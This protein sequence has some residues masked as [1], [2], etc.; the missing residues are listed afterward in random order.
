MSSV[1][2]DGRLIDKND[3]RVSVF[4]HGFLFGD[5][6]WEGM[7][8]FDGSVF[9][10]GDHLASL[11]RSARAI[12]LEIPLGP[13]ELVNAIATTLKAND[14]RDGYVRVIVSRGAGTLG[15]DPRKC[16][17]MVIVIAEEIGQYPRELTDH[18]IET[19]AVESPRP[20]PPVTLL[21][22]AGF[23]TAKAAALRAGCFEALLFDPDSIL[24][25]ASEAAVF[26]VSS[27][28]VDT[29]SIDFG[30]LEP[31]MRSAVLELVGEAGRP[32]S[33][34]PVD[35][36]AISAADEV[37]LASAAGG[38]MAV[39]KLDGQPIGDGRVG[40]VT[41]QIQGLLAEAVRERR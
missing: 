14:R 18:G 30:G 24:I 4:D 22:R 37:F 11:A 25:G 9:R 15:L 13:A 32:T 36:Q 39:A 20:H 1:W 5:G 27:G 8:A 34:W 6:V 21:S 23:V 26:V 7:R 35:R 16:E 2:I 28:S 17:P 29:S 10:L 12:S 3:A 40:P 33:I 31:V 38:I 41:R 19:I